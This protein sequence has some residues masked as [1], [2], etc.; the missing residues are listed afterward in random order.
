[1]LSGY[2]FIIVYCLGKQNLADILSRC[3]D[4]TPSLQEVNKQASI[5]LPTLQ[6]KLARAEPSLQGV[7]ASE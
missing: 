7:L 2:N 5:L 1:M 3:P 4:Y 6:K